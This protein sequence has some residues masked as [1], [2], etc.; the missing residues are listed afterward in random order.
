ME[1]TKKISK[2]TPLS[3][4]AYIHYK[5]NSNDNPIKGVFSFTY[6]V[7]ERSDSTR[8]IKGYV[9]ADGIERYLD[10]LDRYDTWRDWKMILYMDEKTLERGLARA[11]FAYPPIRPQGGKENGTLTDEQ[12]RIYKEQFKKYEEEKEKLNKEYEA[13]K[14]QFLDKIMIHP[15][16]ILAI[17][18]W[19]HFKMDDSGAQVAPQIL[20]CFRLKAFEDFPDIPVF[21]RDADTVFVTD[22]QEEL[23]NIAESYSSEYIH[24]WEY[25]YYKGFKAKE[26]K[27]RFCLATEHTYSKS[28]HTAENKPPPPPPEPPTPP[29][30]PKKNTG[31]F[32]KRGKSLIFQGAVS[33]APEPPPPPSKVTPSMIGF[34]AGLIGSLGGIPEWK[35]GSLW[36]KS[37]DYM[38][39]KCGVKRTELRT[40]EKSGIKVD[41]MFEFETTRKSPAMDEPIL[42]YIILPELYDTI[43][44]LM[45]L[46]IGGDSI[47]I[48]K[49]ED[50][51]PKKREGHATLANLLSGPGPNMKYKQENVLKALEGYKSV[52]SVDLMRKGR[53]KNTH[54]N[55]KDTKGLPPRKE[56]LM[57]ELVAAGPSGAKIIAKKD[58]ET[59]IPLLEKVGMRDVA[60]ELAL[61]GLD[62]KLLE[63][64]REA[65]RENPKM[66]RAPTKKIRDDPQI[67]GVR[68]AF[69]SPH[70]HTFLKKLV[71]YLM[72]VTKQKLVCKLPRG[73][74]NYIGKPANRIV[75]SRRT[76]R[77]RENNNN[78]A[79]DNNNNDKSV[80]RKR[81]G[82][83][84]SRSR[85][86]RGTAKNGS[87]TRGAISSGR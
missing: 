83:L 19:D 75:F 52:P 40:Q 72:E 69:S 51:F 25:E 31:L 36:Q 49:S 12:E 62:P 27:Y 86:A 79:S 61:D 50:V 73:D 1:Y 44:F 81:R 60:L 18:H 63:I 3:D 80:S 10:M 47:N 38:T 15:R 82:S 6:Y 67:R 14:K 53:Y 41:V 84:T 7:P 70:P 65:E 42:A 54:V 45:F 77:Q 55:T 39:G 29:E 17:V 68:Y 37:I 13:R 59:Y 85:S 4:G 35:N 22:R 11:Y 21:V 71:T 8:G 76:R 30:P 64:E 56:V 48:F 43:F 23:S 58:I 9:Y 28:W 87:T 20:R 24:E 74:R 46:L 5:H 34:F 57:K 26:S 66:W 33:G 78:T 2:G 32:F 16:V